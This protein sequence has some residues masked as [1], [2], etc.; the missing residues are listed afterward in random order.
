MSDDLYGICPDRFAPV[1]EAMADQF[2]QGLELGARFAFAIEGEV[3][4][5]LWGGYADRHRSSP[6]DDRTLTPVFSTTKAV[7]SILIARAVDA[8]LLDYDQPVSDLWPK[9][10]SEGKGAI[11]VAQTLSHQDGLAALLEPMDPSDW[12]DWDLV[13]S[14]LAA[15]APMWP[16][17]TASGYHPTTFGYTAGEIFRRADGR[18]MGQALAEDFAKPF[19]LEIYIGLPES[20]DHRVADVERPTAV[21]NFGEMTEIRRAAFMTKWAA[22]GP[23][24]EAAWRRAEI[25]SANGHA[26]ARSLA[27]LMG[28]MACDGRLDGLQVLRRETIEDAS[29]ERIGGQDLVLPYIMS[30]GAGFM[31]NSSLAIYGPSLES[32]GHSGWGGSCAFADPQR[33]I[34]GAYVMNRQSPDLLGDPRSRRLIDTAYSC[35]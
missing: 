4:I 32:F 2:A 24:T 12:Y 18:T 35:L 26:D 27:R 15:M 33:R 8:G 25:P 7:A 9:F 28:M 19:G 14:K 10:E 11:S 3:V 5:D 13:T 23:R 16:P 30:W 29:K 1:R 20:E 34:S 17:G 21:P 31:R 6:F 22:P